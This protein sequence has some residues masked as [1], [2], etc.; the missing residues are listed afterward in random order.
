MQPGG[1]RAIP[2]TAA[3]APREAETPRFVAGSTMRHVIVMTATGS[4]GLIAIFMVDLLSLLYI[5]WLGDPRLTAGVGL[6]TVVLFLATSINVGLM[7][8]VGAL[9]SRALGAGERGKARRLA[10]SCS[11][12][13]AAVGLLISGLLLPILPSLLNWIGASSETL[14]VARDFLWIALPSNALM[15]VGMGFSGVLR[16]VGDAKRAMYVTL[17][18]AI[19]TAGLDPLFIFGLGL[20]PNGAALAMVISRVLFAAVGFHGVARVHGLL[21]RPRIQDAIADLRPMFGIAVP[22]ILTNVA[23]PLANGFFAAILARYGDPAIAATAI[24]DRVV[25]VAFGGLFALSGSVGPILGQNWGAGRFD[26][27]RQALKDAVAFMAVYVGAVWILLVAL[28]APLAVLFHA[29]GLTG[30]LLVFFC[31]LSGAMWFFI[32]LLF[33]A[34]A[35]FNNLGFP[36]YSTAFNWARATLG[37]VPFALAGAALA[38]PKGA[39]A[40]IALGSVPFGIAAIVT[41]FRAVGRLEVQAL[42]R[43]PY[44]TGSSNVTALGSLA[45]GPEEASA[46]AEPPLALPPDAR[47]G[48]ETAARGAPTA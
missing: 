35:A 30:E 48:A 19:L 29:E 1:C 28:S 17:S 22:A 37:M 24:I 7:I 42:A 8:A 33:V 16:A 44:P 40:G 32:G 21:A 47:K 41:A 2:M 6:A 31:L 34:N 5:S 10:T 46:E 36:L 25:P 11:L 12:H 9:V 15:A 20:G 3:P 45:A 14:D 38:G 18:G 13:M 27:M 26:R 43:S 23:T 4:V 39:L